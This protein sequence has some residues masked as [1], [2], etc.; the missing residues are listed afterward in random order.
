MIPQA[1]DILTLDEQKAL[2]QCSTARQYDCMYRKRLVAATKKA[3][4]ILEK[5]KA[6]SVS[7]KYET[8]NPAW[9]VVRFATL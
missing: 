2:T 1:K 8:N 7:V 5:C 4:N 3:H 6:P 9:T